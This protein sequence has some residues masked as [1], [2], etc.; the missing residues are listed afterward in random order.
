QISRAE[1]DNLLVMTAQRRERHID[2]PALA[3]CVVHQGVIDC[4][5][6]REGRYG[7]A[8]GQLAARLEERREKMSMRPF[9][10]L[11]S[12]QRNP[13]EHL[14]ARKGAFDHTMRALL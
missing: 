10:R 11:F 7:E 13:R 5:W 9:R 6:G 12:G 8:R 2:V 4:N 1:R 3:R 14:N